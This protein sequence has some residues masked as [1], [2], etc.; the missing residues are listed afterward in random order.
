MFFEAIIA[1]FNKPEIKHS[2]FA[3][4]VQFSV[5]SMI[6]VAKMLGAQIWIQRIKITV[7]CG[8]LQD[9]FLANLH[10]NLGGVC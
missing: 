9:I 8:L 1:S 4:S 7:T 6:G 2:P 10:H 5:H 3:S